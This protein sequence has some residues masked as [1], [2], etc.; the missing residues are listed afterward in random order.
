MKRNSFRLIYRVT[1]PAPRRDDPEKSPAIML[2]CFSGSCFP[3]HRRMRRKEYSMK[4][5]TSFP[6][7]PLPLKGE[8]A[9]T[10]Q[11]PGGGVQ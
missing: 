9:V 4:S 11:S 3:G 1:V 10:R 7:H 6:G 5:V 2:T 8:Y